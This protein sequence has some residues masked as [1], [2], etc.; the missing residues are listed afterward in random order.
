L[1]YEVYVHGRNSQYSFYDVCGYS[2][3]NHVLL[4]AL[5]IKVHEP[6]AYRM[7]YV[8]LCETKL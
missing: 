4:L 5:Q 3:D 8:Y 2:N 1:N 6:I 7:M